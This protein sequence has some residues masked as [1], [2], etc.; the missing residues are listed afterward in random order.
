MPDD[1]AEFLEDMF[2]GERLRL[3]NLFDGKPFVYGS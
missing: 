1:V 3:R 2:A